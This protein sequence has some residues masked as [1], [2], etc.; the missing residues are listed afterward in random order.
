MSVTPSLVDTEVD[1]ISGT[2]GNEVSLSFLQEE[3]PSLK[4]PS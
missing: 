1:G 2:L 4:A 3:N